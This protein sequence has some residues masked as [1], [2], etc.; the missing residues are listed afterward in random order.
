MGNDSNTRKYGSGVWKPEAKPTKNEC[1][2][3]TQYL[4]QRKAR[5]R[6]IIYAEHIKT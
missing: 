6:D 3:S 5:G 2:E 4:K 1:N